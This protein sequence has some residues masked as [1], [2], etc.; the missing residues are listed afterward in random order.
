MGLIED[1]PRTVGIGFKAGGD[2]LWI[3]GDRTHGSSQL[4]QSLWLREAQGLESGT[5]PKVDLAAERKNGE[6]VRGLIDRGEVNAVHDVSDG[7][8]AVCLTE[9]A[10]SGQVGCEVRRHYTSDAWYFSE[11]QGCYVVA[12]P[13]RWSFEESTKFAQEAVDAGIVA[14]ALGVV[15][16]DRIILRDDENAKIADIP[17]ADLRAANERF[18]REWMDV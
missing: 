2:A 18:F 11:M 7:G 15:G 14:T 16:G 10:L 3:I 4:G 1:Y 6:F 12:L 5:P 8:L 13:G 9:M 17:L